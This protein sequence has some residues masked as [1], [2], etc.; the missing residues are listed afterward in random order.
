MVLDGLY[1]SLIGLAVV[2]M[3]LIFLLITISLLNFFDKN[4]KK[5]NIETDILAPSKNSGN[6]MENL[7]AAIAL[8]LAMSESNPTNNII[9]KSKESF[10]TSMLNKLLDKFVKQSAPPSV[11][12]RLLKFKHVHFS[13][14]YPTTLVIN[15]NQDKKI[16]ANYRKYLE[17]SFRKELNLDSIQLKLI[18]KK[19]LNPY[20]DKKNILTGRQEKK[21]QRLIKHKSKSKNI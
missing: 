11:G 21:R 19:S 12:G 2:F 3:V 18:F 14:I 1:M 10:S 8:S 13:G 6:K 15:A 4:P 7:V 5:K 17:N 9:K 20:Q 16:P